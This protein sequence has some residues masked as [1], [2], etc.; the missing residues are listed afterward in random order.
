MT[1]GSRCSDAERDHSPSPPS[2]RLRSVAV[3]NS[4]AMPS[5]KT[6]RV[7][8]I[9]AKKQKQ[10]RQ[11]P[12][13]IRFRT[14]NTV[15]NLPG[16]LIVARRSSPAQRNAGQVGKKEGKGKGEIDMRR[17]PTASVAVDIIL[18]LRVSCR[19]A[20]TTSGDTGAAPRSVCKYVG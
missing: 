18:S 8:K 11:V 10:N 12:Q 4:A 17:Q 14:G 1:I 6:F 9:L 7:K 5:H 13:W 20:T 3:V 19:S 16:L 15:C 2:V